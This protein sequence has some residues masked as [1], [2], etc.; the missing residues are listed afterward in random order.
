MCSEVCVCMY[1][2]CVAQGCRRARSVLQGGWALGS[3]LRHVRRLGLVLEG[4][5][6]LVCYLSA[7][8]RL[9]V[10]VVDYWFGR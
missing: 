6:E 7:V 5:G 1:V 8:C 2:C 10:G 4:R 9:R 3:V